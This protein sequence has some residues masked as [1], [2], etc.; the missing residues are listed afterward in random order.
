MTTRLTLFADVILPLPIPYLFTYRVPVELNEYVEV[1]KRV[2]VQ[3]GKKK[4]YSGI[5]SHLHS[6]PPKAYQAKYIDSIL[7]ESPVVNESQLK[8]WKWLSSY[9][10]CSIGEVMNAALP[11]GLK[12]VSKTKI[13]RNEEVEISPN[14][15]SDKEYLILEALE[16]RNVLEMSE[17]DSIVSSSSSYKVIKSLL[18]KNAVIVAEQ[19]KEKYKPKVEKYVQLPANFSENEVRNAF[20]SLEKAPKQLEAFMMFLQLKKEAES[21]PKKKLIRLANTSSSIVKQLIVKGF[22]CE[23]SKE[24]SRIETKNVQENIDSLSVIQEAAIKEIKVYFEQDKTVLLHG[25]TGSGKT[26]VY[27]QLIQEQLEKGNQVLYLL[28]EI[29]LTTQIITRLRKK[30]GDKVGIYHSKS[31]SH[32]R[33]EVWNE[34][35]KKEKSRF[36]IIIGARSAIFLPF[37]NLGLAIVDEEHDSSYKQQD[38]APRYQGRDASLY[39]SSIHGAK[40]LLGSATPSIESY[41]N[42]KEKKFG[43]VEITERYGEVKLP[44]IVISDL[45]E[46][47]RKKKMKSH[48]SQFLIDEMQTYLDNKEQIILF[49]NRRGYNPSWLCESCGWVP[50]CKNCD[51]SLTY[52]KYTH[53]Q[54][55]HYCGFT[56]KPISKCK[57][58]GSN[59]LK[60]QGFGTEK[61]EEDLSLYF[62][63]SAVKRMDYDTTRNKNGYQHIIDNFEQGAIDILVG[64][65]MV[66]KGLDFDNV[67][68]VGVLNADSL[69][70]YPDFRS[71]ERSFQL[72]TQVAGRAGRK[73]KQGK[74][75][76]Q[77]YSPEHPVIERV[78]ENDFLGMYNQEIE[79]REKYGYPPFYRLIKITVKH[80]ERER[81]AEAADELGKLLKKQLGARVLGPETPAIARIK[82]LY[83]NQLMIKF[84]RKISPVKLKEF[85]RETVG[86]FNNQ[87]HFKSVRIVLDVDFY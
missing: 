3:F 71:F 78:I 74:V 6:I 60:M 12:L 39:L 61:I 37:H 48:F 29:A 76:I 54:K 45:K 32:E 17:V 22:L 79:E 19:L 81:S 30:F 31:N 16:I 69:L 68:M 63:T 47:T 70:H 66:T 65:Q 46:A 67:G 75:I 28:P 25:V 13:I 72:L 11:T 34:L 87:P 82:N 44:E 43:L 27:I 18:E 7:D 77:T 55:C 51:I 40:V 9:Y 42:A 20:E 52:H 80:R 62:P 57:A 59:S 4:L 85:I 1:G 56:E 49:Q 24:E 73:E 41:W 23:V 86:K 8:F 83:I 35:L 26:E 5:V 14:E 2:V 84:E 38:P 21:I 58:C 33:V 64:T 36:Q 50:Q 10:L 53:Y 15:L